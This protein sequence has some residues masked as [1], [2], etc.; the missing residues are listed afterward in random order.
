MDGVGGIAIADTKS[1]GCSL[2]QPPRSQRE[3]IIYRTAPADES[4]ET[5]IW[6]EIARSG[7]D[8]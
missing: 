4:D 5:M 2:L 7:L 1:S 3:Q 6:D 8:A